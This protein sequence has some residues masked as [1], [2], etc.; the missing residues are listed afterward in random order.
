MDLAELYQTIILDHNKNPCNFHVMENADVLKEGFNPMCGDH[1]FIYVKLEK[2]IVVDISFK[3]DGC[4]ISKSSAS[5]MTQKLKGKSLDEALDLIKEFHNLLLNKEYDEKK[6]G[7]LKIF[8]TLH[9]FPG[10]VKCATLSWHT[11]EAALKQSSKDVLK[12]E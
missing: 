9:K 3:G 11:A 10:R 6:L 4:A 1:F 8:S 5:M 7:E 12:T 2:N